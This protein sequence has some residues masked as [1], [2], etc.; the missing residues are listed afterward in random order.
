MD[1]LFRG[2]ESALF[3]R[4]MACCRDIDHVFVRWVL[5]APA[6]P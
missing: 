3:E 2:D 5:L 6:L 4:M 1:G